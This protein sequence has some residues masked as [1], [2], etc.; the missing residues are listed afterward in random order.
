MEGPAE[1]EGNEGKVFHDALRP[2][3]QSYLKQTSTSAKCTWRVKE[4]RP[5][6]KNSFCP[7]RPRVSA[8]YCCLNANVP[9][10]IL[11]VV[12][13]PPMPTWQVLGG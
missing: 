2:V 3:Q 4:R 12:A 1:L 13:P 11:K 10:G 9:V 6:W 7:I 5:N 8:F